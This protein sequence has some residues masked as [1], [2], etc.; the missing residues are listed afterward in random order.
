MELLTGYTFTLCVGYFTIHY[1]AKA[2]DRR[3]Q[4][5]TVYYLLRDTGK[6]AQTKLQRSVAS[7]ICITIVSTAPYQL[8]YHATHQTEYRSEVYRHVLT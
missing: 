7:G 5:F 6:V 2:P 8:S 3:D 1:W 4:L